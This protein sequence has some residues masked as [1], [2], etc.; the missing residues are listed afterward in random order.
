M[1]GSEPICSANS[2]PTRQLC[3]LYFLLNHTPR[4]SAKPLTKNKGCRR[5]NGKR[6]E[7]QNQGG[8][9]ENRSG[10]R[11][12]LH[13]AHSPPEQGGG[14]QALYI[15]AVRVLWCGCS[16]LCPITD[17]NSIDYRGTKVR[18]QLPVGSP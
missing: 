12:C 17:S 15:T 1:T 9:C 3:A 6:K 18:P 10:R 14:A 8:G 16:S 7:K 2:D 4:R 11:M 13:M 5:E